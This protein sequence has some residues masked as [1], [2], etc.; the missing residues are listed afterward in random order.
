MKHFLVFVMN[1]KKTYETISCRLYI[2]I[3]WIISTITSESFLLILVERRRSFTLVERLA[4]F[5][6]INRTLLAELT[7]LSIVVPGDRFTA[8]VTR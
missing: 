5:S 7:I 6:M 2:S 4:K 1:R 3:L 8:K